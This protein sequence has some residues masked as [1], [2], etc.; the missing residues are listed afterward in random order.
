MTTAEARDRTE[1]SAPGA[2]PRFRP[3]GASSKEK[4]LEAV[5][6][7]SPLDPE[8]GSNPGWGALPIRTHALPGPGLGPDLGPDLGLG[9]GPDPAPPHTEDMGGRAR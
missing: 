4:N 9:L 5:F 1:G 7:G 3:G 6:L 2:P 8:V